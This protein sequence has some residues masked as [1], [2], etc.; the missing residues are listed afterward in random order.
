MASFPFSERPCL[1]TARLKE[2]QE[3]IP[4]AILASICIHSYTFTCI[5][6]AYNII[7]IHRG[8]KREG[9]GSREGGIERGR[10]G[11]EGIGRVRGRGEGGRDEGE[12]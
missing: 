7:G 3:D 5:H 4:N 12:G 2:I 8:E 1:K 10:G 9:E 6:C 11:R